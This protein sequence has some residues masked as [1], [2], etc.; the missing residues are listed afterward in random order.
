VLDENVHVE[1]KKNDKGSFSEIMMWWSQ[2]QV[3]N[4]PRE[5]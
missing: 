5:K 1:F 2:G 3:S 4:K